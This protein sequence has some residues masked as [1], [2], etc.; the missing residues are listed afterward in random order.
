MR[1]LCD[2]RL[3]S[4]HFACIGSVLSFI[5]LSSLVGMFGLKA[6]RSYD[7]VHAIFHVQSLYLYSYCMT[8]HV[9]A[10][11]VQQSY[12]WCMFFPA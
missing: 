4:R 11:I 8:G 6:C 9:A 3:L 1:I 7:S 10:A 12:S 2:C 5:G